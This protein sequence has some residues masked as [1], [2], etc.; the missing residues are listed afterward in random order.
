MFTEDTVGTVFGRRNRNAFH[1]WYL[2]PQRISGESVPLMQEG[3][4][5]VGSLPPSCRIALSRPGMRLM[6]A[7]QVAV[8]ERYGFDRLRIGSWLTRCRNEPR[9]EMDSIAEELATHRPGKDLG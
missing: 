7:D 5:L 9:L 2:V 4:L 1:S 6:I 3:L 8:L